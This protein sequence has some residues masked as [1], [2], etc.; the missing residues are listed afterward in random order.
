MKTCTQCGKEMDQQAAFCPS[1]G[2]PNPVTEPEKESPTPENLIQNIEPDTT[3][4]EKANF[5][6]VDSSQQEEN[7]LEADT[8]NT[9]PA[10]LAEKKR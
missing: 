2:T 5:L 6:P 7:P 8:E 9:A 3:D 1:C 10:P 4:T